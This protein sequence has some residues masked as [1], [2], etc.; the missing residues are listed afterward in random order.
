VI[1]MVKFPN[2]DASIFL[3]AGLTVKDAGISGS[4]FLQVITKNIAPI[5][6]NISFRKPDPFF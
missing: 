5:S 4:G 1:S 2:G 3:L 6:R